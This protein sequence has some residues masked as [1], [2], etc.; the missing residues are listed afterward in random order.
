MEDHIHISMAGSGGG[1]LHTA[2]ARRPDRVLGNTDGAES[3][4]K[5]YRA[6]IEN[7]N[8]RRCRARKSS[9]KCVRISDRRSF[10][11]SLRRRGPKRIGQSRSVSRNTTNQIWIY[12]KR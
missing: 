9:H 4:D 5:V 10:L 2:L 7:W 11:K 12:E 3:G 1:N 8:R 6:K